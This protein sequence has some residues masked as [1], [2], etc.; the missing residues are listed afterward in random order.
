MASSSEAYSMFETWKNLNTPFR[1]T[2]M[3]CD[4]SEIVVSGRIDVLDKESEQIEFSTVDREFGM[5]DVG[6][7]DFSIEDN[8][9]VVSRKDAEW[10]VFEVDLEE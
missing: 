3:E 2:T 6:E 4:K 7:A 5:L 1:V 9:V 8:R 10:L